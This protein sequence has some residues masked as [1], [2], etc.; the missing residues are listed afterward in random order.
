MLEFTRGFFEASVPEIAMEG[1]MSRI[2]TR[3]KL[4]D[5]PSISPDKGRESLRVAQCVHRHTLSKYTK[6]WLLINH[7]ILVFHPCV[8]TGIGARIQHDQ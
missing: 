4:M 8:F 7:H 3:R 6:S 5:P 1:P 2:A